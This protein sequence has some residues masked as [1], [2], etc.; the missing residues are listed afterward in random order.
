MST[1]AAAGMSVRS[2]ATSAVVSAGRAAMQAKTMARAKSVLASASH[3]SLQL[4]A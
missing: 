2:P 1:A 4:F 3:S